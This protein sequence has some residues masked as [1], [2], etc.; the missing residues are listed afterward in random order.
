MAC[1]T[2]LKADV[3]DRTVSQSYWP[4]ASLSAWLCTL[5]ISAATENECDIFSSKLW[6][7]NKELSLA[8]YAWWW[9]RILQIGKV[10]ELFFLLHKGHLPV[11]ICV[12]VVLMF[13]RYVFTG[14][15]FQPLWAGKSMLHQNWT[16]LPHLHRLFQHWSA[17]Q[18]LTSALF[19]QGAHVCMCKSILSLVKWKYLY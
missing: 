18:W 8:L 15:S 4:I 12:S 7:I 14:V 3:S 17:I 16:V 13:P 6:V 19:S 11:G 2:I 5:G 9:R 1:K 10:W